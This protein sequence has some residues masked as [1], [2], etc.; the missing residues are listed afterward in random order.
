MESKKNVAIIGAGV[1]GLLSMKT[2][3][4]GFRVT[5]YEITND[6]GGLWKYR[7]ENVP[8]VASVCKRTVMNTSRE[9]SAFSDFPPPKD[10]PIFMPHQIVYDYITSYADKHSLRDHVRFRRKV[11]LVQE[12]EDFEY[13]GKW[14][15]TAI[16]LETSNKEV[17]T[18]DAVMI[19]TGCNSNPFIPSLPGLEEFKGNVFHSWHYK[20]PSKFSNRR[21]LVVG[22]GNSGSDVAVDLCGVAK[23]IIMSSNNG[24]WVYGRN[25]PS[26]EPWD[27]YFTSR[28]NLWLFERLPKFI[29]NK[30]MKNKFKKYFNTSYFNIVPKKDVFRCIP[31]INDCILFLL[32]NG[33]IRIR[34]K[35]KKF[36]AE[37]VL[38]EGDQDVT[39]IDDV[40]F[41]TGYS[42]DL[43]FLQKK[44]YS[45][46]LYNIIIPPDLKHPTLAFIGF[47]EIPR[48]LAL[49]IEMQAMWFV[50]LLKGKIQLPPR[51]K[52]RKRISNFKKAR[53]ARYGEDSHTHLIME[54]YGDELASE[55]GIK[56]NL[57]S[58]LFHDP[59][60]F[61]SCLK[62][63]LLPYQYRLRGPYAWMGARD[64]IVTD[65]KRLY[66]VK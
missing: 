52:M 31:T 9:M 44:T 8:G 1:S 46:D 35:I 64:A 39:L 26:G 19:C 24:L 60:L 51:E 55:I 28:L 63:P 65:K 37:G 23:T 42:L 50:Q 32:L 29:T 57:L 15:V 11:T 38:F 41:A 47:I 12:A 25:S 20:E 33:N 17:D 16:D 43:P 56:P 59:A 62:G 66:N 53:K 22:T 14:K 21:V 58:M 3:K 27:V 13:K 61:F 18:Y 54:T 10:F 5:C 40:I 49:I 45:E 34:G 7:E 4:E 36:T 48:A 2:C 30:W 6:I